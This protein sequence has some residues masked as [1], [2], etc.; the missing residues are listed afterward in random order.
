MR[1]QKFGH[2]LLQRLVYPG[3]VIACMMRDRTPYLYDSG[4]ERRSCYCY[5]AGQCVI[6]VA[7]IPFYLLQLDISIDR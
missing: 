2:Q 7:G 1:R 6:S 5:I 3:L 4:L